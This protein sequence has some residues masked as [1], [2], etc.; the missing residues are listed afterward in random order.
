MSHQNEIRFHQTQAI[1]ADLK[2]PKT[3]AEAVVAAVQSRVLEDDRIHEIDI[4]T[5]NLVLEEC[6]ILSHIQS[7]EI[8]RPPVDHRMIA[9]AQAPK[10]DPEVLAQT[11]TAPESW[12]THVNGVA[13][14]KWCVYRRPTCRSMK[15]LHHLT[16]GA[17]LQRARIWQRNLK[18][19]FTK[20]GDHICDLIN[21][22][23]LLSPERR[24]TKPKLRLKVEGSWFHSRS[25]F[26]LSMSC[27]GAENYCDTGQLS[28]W[29]T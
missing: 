15:G 7:R 10:S 26:K 8:G 13:T 14:G 16:E 24:D 25:L 6:K 23:F 4:P 20:R 19:P 18:H 22:S 28:T 17:H 9:Y 12:K 3:E 29:L 1:I 21:P 2:H 27:F 5:R 11:L